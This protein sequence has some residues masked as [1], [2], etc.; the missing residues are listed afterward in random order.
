MFLEESND[1]RQERR[2]CVNTILHGRIGW[3]HHLR[4]VRELRFCVDAR[5]PNIF[6]ALKEA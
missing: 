2:D 6:S 1:V 3:L 4:P 5:W